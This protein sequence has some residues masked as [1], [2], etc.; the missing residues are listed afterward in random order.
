MEINGNIPFIFHVLM[1]RMILLQL[2]SLT[3]VN[4]VVRA[5]VF[6]SQALGTNLYMFDKNQFLGNNV[7]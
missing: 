4:R 7:K 6:M 1:Y 2:Y 5:L 3:D